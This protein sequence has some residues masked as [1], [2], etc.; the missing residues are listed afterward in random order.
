MREIKEVACRIRKEL[1]AA[2]WYAQE[3]NKDRDMYPRLAQHYHSLAEGN[4]H[5]VDELHSSVDEMIQE[6]RRSG[7]EIP[8]GMLDVWQFEHEMLVEDADEVRRLLELHK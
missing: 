3:A 7:K 6:V 4:L 1:K 8:S 2:E 5:R